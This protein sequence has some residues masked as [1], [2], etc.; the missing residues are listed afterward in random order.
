MN[1]RKFGGN[2]WEM[3]EQTNVFFCI[4]RSKCRNSPFSASGPEPKKRPHAIHL[5]EKKRPFFQ[6]PRDEV[7]WISLLSWRFSRCWNSKIF[8]VGGFKDFS[9]W[10]FQRFLEFSPWTL[11]RWS[12][13]TIIFFK[14]V[15]SL[16]GNIGT[17]GHDVP[18]VG[19]L[20]RSLW[21]SW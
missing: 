14:G 10:W 13:L 20:S 19:W 9:G 8:L 21:R 15:E 1:V 17:L 5:W 7:P 16:H 12:N 6:R 4:F 3:V 2:G 11:G 18:S